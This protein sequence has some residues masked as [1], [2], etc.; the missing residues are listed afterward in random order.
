MKLANKKKL[1]FIIFKIKF[2]YIKILLIYIIL[3]FFYNF[4]AKY[5]ITKKLIVIVTGVIRTFIIIF[6]NLKFK[7]YFPSKIYKFCATIEI[8]K[9]SNN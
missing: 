3:I 4:S 2:F 9:I 1:S 5:F 8:K 7:L 6:I